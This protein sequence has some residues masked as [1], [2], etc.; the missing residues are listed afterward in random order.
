MSTAA[1]R[2]PLRPLAIG[3][4]G[5]VYGDIGTSPLYALRECFLGHGAVSPS[6]ANILGVLS[7]IFWA[8]VL[9]ISLKYLTFVMR[10]DNDGEGGI[11]ALMT[12]ALPRKRTNRR[13]A[14]LWLGLF[15]AGLLYGDGII[16]PAISV[17]SAI[18]GVHVATPEF[19]EISV[20]ITVV[21]LFVLFR[22]QRYGTG[23]VGFLFGPVMLVWFVVIAALGLAAIVREPGVMAALS[24]HHA[25]NFFV[26]NQWTGFVTLGIV[27]L[28]VTGGEALYADMGHFGALPIRVAWFTIVLPAL[29]L[30]YFGQGALLLARPETINNPFYHLA[31]SSALYPMVALSTV[32]TIIASQAVISGAF[33]LSHQ[34]VQLDYLP[35]LRVI[36]TSK[37]ERGQIYVPVVNWLLF[38][39]VIG[40]VLAFK[41][42]GA[43]SAAY[44]MAVTT[45]MVITAVMLFVVAR[46]KWGWSALAAGGLVTAMLIIDLSFFAANVLKIPSG[47]WF[48]LLVGAGIGTIMLTWSKGREI[49]AKNLGQRLMALSAFFDELSKNPPVRV[50]GAAVYL[51]SQGEGV[52]LALFYNW[53]H[54]TVLHRPLVLLTIQIEDRPWVPL[55]QRLVIEPKGNDI[56][57][58]VAHYGFKQNPD[59]PQLASLIRQHRVDLMD[60]ST[61]YFLSHVSLEPTSGGPMFGWQKH[62]FAWLARNASHASDYFRLPPDQT[63]VIGARLEL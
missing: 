40:T 17:L 13:S 63:V 48:P 26:Q 35:R 37:D 1:A 60:E 41:T 54:N 9:V 46:E 29:L 24:P 51:T 10:A 27:F 33:S 23:R 21:I 44:G 12:L 6:E 34:A 19:E 38:I 3:A 32:A 36:H 42:S 28:V 5:V 59:V 49:V 14:L 7:L 20:V 25:V 4:L 31:P 22:M 11:L 45:T 53:R 18:E 16:T 2:R 15:G 8:L 52:P 47:G 61:T 62:L 43:L 50:P 30:N 57:Q 55:G 58:M 39:G 56:Y